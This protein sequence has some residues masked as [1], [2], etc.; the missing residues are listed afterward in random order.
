MPAICPHCGL[1]SRTT[2]DTDELEG[3]LEQLRAEVVLLRA[4]LRTAAVV[5]DLAYG[6]LEAD[7]FNAVERA[8]EGMRAYIED[9]IENGGYKQR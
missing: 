7:E 1:A 2:D 8:K 6:L 4:N 9:Q 3:E 5:I